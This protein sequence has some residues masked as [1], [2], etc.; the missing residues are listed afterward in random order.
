MIDE[1]ELPKVPPAALGPMR[2]LPII[3]RKVSR[4]R[5]GTRGGEGDQVDAS[6]T[7]ES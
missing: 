1:D 5:E 2:V 7:K 6:D 3:G 4:L